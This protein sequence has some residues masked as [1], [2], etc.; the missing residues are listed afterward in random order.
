MGAE[1][2]QQRRESELERRLEI[3]REMEYKKA[4]SAGFAVGWAIGFCIDDHPLVL[5]S[6]SKLENECN[7]VE[8]KWMEKNDIEERVMWPISLEV[9]SD[10]VITPSGK[11]YDRKN[12]EKH[13]EMYGKDPIT[14][15]PLLKSQLIPNCAVKE[16]IEHFKIAHA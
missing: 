9:M 4:W 14:R 6:R 7:Q 12:I 1:Q 11:T 16:I 2:S 15:N 5:K 13:I 3:Q 10:P 8:V